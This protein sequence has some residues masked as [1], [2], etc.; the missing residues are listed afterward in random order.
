MVLYMNK[1]NTLGIMP[2]AFLLLSLIL[3][4]DLHAVS[5]VLVPSQAAIGIDYHLQCT[6]ST[7]FTSNC[8]I[9]YTADASGATKGNYSYTVSYLINPNDYCTYD[10][11]QLLSGATSTTLTSLP[12]PGIPDAGDY[13]C[14]HGTLTG[15]MPLIPEQVIDVNVSATDTN[16]GNTAYANSSVT[17]YPMLISPTIS[18]SAHTVYVSNSISFS[19]SWINSSS[20]STGTPP[21]NAVIYGTSSGGC[22]TANPVLSQNGITS[23]TATISFNA[24]STTGT[25]Y[26][27]GSV[28]DSSYNSSQTTYS[29]VADLVTAQVPTVAINIPQTSF[30]AGGE[31]V[32]VG[33]V[34]HNGIGP[35]TVAVYASNGTKV[36]NTL[37][38]GS[39]NSSGSITFQTPYAS[40]NHNYHLVVVDEQKNDGGSGNIY[41]FD[42]NNFTISVSAPSAT[43]SIT[44]SSLD[45]GQIETFNV[46]VSGGVG[47]FDVGIYNETGDTQVGGNLIIASPG[48]SNSIS[49]KVAN[50]GSFSYNAIFADTGVSPSYTFSA[51]TSTMQVSNVLSAEL[52]TNIPA[53]N[54]IKQGQQVEINGIAVGGTSP[55]TYNFIVSNAMGVL[56]SVSSSSNTFSFNSL[57]F[58]YVGAPYSVNVVI[59]DSASTPVTAG[60]S[61]QQININNTPYITHPIASGSI[62]DVGQSVTYSNTTIFDGENPFTANILINGNVVDTVTT[63]ALSPISYTYTPLSAGQ[64]KYNISVVDT[65]NATD[66]SFNST[67]NTVTVNTHP[68]VTLSVPANVYYVNET[69]PIN[70]TISGGT[71]LFT[72]SIYRKSS[73]L[74]L[75]IDTLS[76][77]PDGS[78]IVNKTIEYS[79]NYILTVKSTDMGTSSPYNS[80]SNSVPITI[81]PIPSNAPRMSMTV[82]NTVLDLG[83]S[84]SITIR[85]VNN[86]SPVN[87]SLYGATRPLNYST[88]KSSY[89]LVDTFTNAGPNATL[90]YTFT[91]SSPDL[92]YFYAVGKDNAYT[93][94]YVFENNSLFQVIT[95]TPGYPLYICEGASGNDPISFS[96][97]AESNGTYSSVG[98]S[99][100][101]VCVMNSTPGGQQIE[102][103]IIGVSSNT[104][105][106]Y[107]NAETRH[108]SDSFSLTYNVPSASS[109]VL[110]AGSCG[111]YNCTVVSLPSGCTQELR[112]QG[113]DTFETEYFAVC[114]NQPVGSHRFTMY[115]EGSGEESSFALAAYVFNGSVSFSN[116]NYGNSGGDSDPL[117]MVYNQTRT[118]LNF[119]PGLS[120]NGTI[121]GGT[122]SIVANAIVSGGSGNFTFDWNVRA[123]NTTNTIFSYTNATNALVFNNFST[124]KITDPRNGTYVFNIAIVDN[125]TT[126]PYHLS[127]SKTFY[128]GILPLSASCSSPG[129]VGQYA[130]ANVTCTGTVVN[131]LPWSLYVNGQLYGTTTNGTIEWSTQNAPGTYT[132]TFSNPGSVLY[133]AYTASTSLTVQQAG[134]SGFNPVGVPSTIPTTIFTTIPSTVPPT[135]IPQN[136][137]NNT[138]LNLHL[139]ITN[140]NT[141]IN[142]GS[143]GIIISI[144]SNSTTPHSAHLIIKNETAL[145]YTITNYTK[146]AVLDLNLTAANVTTLINV[147][148]PYNC[149]ISGSLLKPFIYVN[150]TLEGITPFTVNASACTVTFQVPSDPVVGLYYRNSTSAANTTSTVAPVTTTAQQTNTTTTSPAPEA[151]PN[152]ILI[153]V[154]VIILVVIIAAALYFMKSRK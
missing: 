90:H 45:Q 14:P 6:N 13:P 88:G 141:D 42:S 46:G 59:T 114:M 144:H 1:M 96:W 9:Y 74:N 124:Y 139:N 72:A 8:T 111:Y 52:S 134:S 40:G 68:I 129:N 41:T 81:L 113:T 150:G 25:Y 28:K 110:L 51:P 66:Y 137:T 117:F 53:T 132:F 123:F 147:T 11:Q 49:I 94:Q 58:T 84:T 15:T 131:G 70:V 32:G 151:Q 18:Q 30:D 148:I 108:L 115:D 112:L 57:N 122:N 118:S 3:I 73:L 93:P 77:V 149:G 136:S 2:L 86:T 83:Q 61:S 38:I 5:V 109:T 143:T 12:L 133:R 78:Y 119:T 39:P 135:T 120:A 85:L 146:I 97:N 145:N 43:L 126:V 104:Y 142:F 121:N 102:S 33:F 67:S 76:E 24:P 4:S 26:Y 95:G 138:E 127:L 17:I 62:F 29:S 91:P 128:V 34:I 44:N 106:L 154:G 23:D 55:F 64:F 27:C 54:T 125:N 10:N 99:L 36:S 63:N 152:Y 103:A 92:Y 101:N 100:S 79:G 80:I 20:Y 71:G 47:P 19:L 22:N 153:V 140:R 48:G 31:S 65:G 75:S 56:H 98:N 16:T 107:T 130:I 105:A 69:I 89:S 37:T 60:S 50:T 21:Y 116:I 87:V 7:G 82:N 35:F